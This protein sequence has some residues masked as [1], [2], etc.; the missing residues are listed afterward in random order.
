M[1]R[2]SKLDDYQRGLDPTTIVA[3]PAE[4]E[5]LS[6]SL[7]EYKARLAPRNTDYLDPTLDPL[8]PAYKVNVRSQTLLDE[9]IEFDLIIQF[10]F[11]DYNSLVGRFTRGYA[12]YHIQEERL[13]F[14]KDYWRVDGATTESEVEM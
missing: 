9:D 4:K 3:T 6:N 12:A 2:F 11:S 1:F 7:V 13:V 10:P 8:F 5:L 14:L